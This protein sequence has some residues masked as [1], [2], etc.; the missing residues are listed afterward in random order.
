M[1]LK[2]GNMKRALATGL[3]LALF[4]I[5]L[6]SQV[7][8]GPVN[9]SMKLAWTNPDN[10]TLS[11]APTFEYRLRDSTQAGVVTALTN[12]NCAGTPVACTSQLTQSNVDAL[13]RVGVHQLTLTLFRTDV[14]ESPQSLP[15]SLR[16]PSGA[17]INLRIIP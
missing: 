5:T 13:N 10:I 14:G 3:L 16:S 4:S 11:D 17:A 8:Q 9:T 12:V 6:N 7:T 1:L 2:R 15:F